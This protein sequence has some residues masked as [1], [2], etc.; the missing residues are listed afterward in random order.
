M[1][2]FL[3]SGGIYET[4]LRH[5]QGKCGLMAGSSPGVV[6]GDQKVT[7]S[8]QLL[9]LTTNWKNCAIVTQML[10]RLRMFWVHVPDPPFSNMTLYT[11]LT[12]EFQMQMIGLLLA[13]NK[14][15]FY[16]ACECLA[17]CLAQ[18]TVIT[19]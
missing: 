5:S 11:L 13:L 4:V 16:L 3:H 10:I 7:D 15:M 17:H 2:S 8:D 19:T 14:I 18:C 6:F 1:Y 12:S 9:T